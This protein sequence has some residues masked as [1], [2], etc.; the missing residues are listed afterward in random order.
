MKFDTSLL[1][2]DL[3]DMPALTQAAEAMGFAGIW[4]AETAHDAFL[5]L[6]L[7]AE[8]SRQLSLGT[9]IALAFSRSP[10][11]LA[12][13]AWDLARFSQGRFI[14]GLGTQVKGHNERRIGVKWEK[15]VEKMREVILAMR[16]FWDCWQHGTKLNFRGEF[17]K[18]TLMT[19]FFNPGPHDYPHVPV[20]I[21]GVN[22]RMCQLAGELCEG[23]HVHPLHTARTIREVTLPHIE[24]GLA[25]SG[26]RRGDIELTTSI[27]VVPTDDPV[28]A[29][30]YEADA[31]QQIAF[32]AS[33][34]AYKIVF[35]VHGW[36][37][38][39]EQL[40]ALAARGRWEEMP[41][42]I[43]DEMMA[44][45]VVSGTW[46]ELPAKI[47]AKYA[48]GLLDRVSYY[49]PF[50]PGQHDEGWRATLAGFA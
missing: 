47:K 48:G 45:F 33:T 50:V 8:H 12:Y 2:S 49:F 18:L 15:P 32:Y 13:L 44:E 4:V 29:R 34:P 41:D 23:F 31:R 19:P 38:T 20:Y 35:D 14:L 24:A 21:A 36:G 5:P 7:A 26:R 30:R 22:P 11:V 1:V 42:L 6:V 3:R 27:F 40:S 43:T 46:A 39:A 10:A 9:G 37:D 16:A 25:Q 28:E 17:F